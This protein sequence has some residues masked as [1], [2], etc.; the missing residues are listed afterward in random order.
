MSNAAIKKSRPVYLNLTQIRLPLPGVVSILHRVSGALLF[1]APIW[2]LFLLDRALA[3]PEG[4]EAAQRYLA[5]IP[6]KLAM[7]LLVWAFAHHFCAGIRY[8]L[9]DLHLGIDLPA[10]RRSSAIVLVI[11][12]LITLF[13]GVKLW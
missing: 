8:L 1:L 11:S 13:V 10:A 12:L 5:M 3:S 9:L 7:L 6:T 2:L 4:Y